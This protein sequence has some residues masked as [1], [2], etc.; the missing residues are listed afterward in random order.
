MPLL[1][2]L[3]AGFAI[4]AHVA[5]GQSADDFSTFKNSMSSCLDM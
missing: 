2:V 4:C 3:Q 1:A 5:A